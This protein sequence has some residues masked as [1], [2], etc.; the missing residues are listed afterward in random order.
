[1]GK[2]LFKGLF[3]KQNDSDPFEKGAPHDPQGKGSL[4]RQ[5]PCR[6]WA[7]CPE[8]DVLAETPYPYKTRFENEKGT[9]PEELIAAAHA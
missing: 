2:N 1:M 9:N 6:Q 3:R 5:R 8:S 4:A 7:S